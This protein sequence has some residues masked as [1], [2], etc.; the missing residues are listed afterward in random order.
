[1]SV[2]SRKIH[3]TIVDDIINKI[4]KGQLKSNQQLPTNKVLA[5]EYS[6]SEVTVRKSILELCNRGYLHSVERV[7]TF[8]KDRSNREERYSVTLSKEINF[9]EPIDSQTIESI[10][11]ALS[12][13]ENHQ[14]LQSVDTRK[15][16]Y[17]DSIPVCYEIDSLFFK[18]KYKEH[19]MLETVEKKQN[20]LH[21]LLDGFNVKK[22]CEITMKSP[23]EFIRKKL[24]LSEDT[25]TFCFSISYY[26]LKGHPIAKSVYY[27][28]GSNVKL[29]GYLVND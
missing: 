28:S 19:T 7:G 3:E 2:I 26:T 12:V 21:A 1:M 13:V 8:V 6:T 16:Q 4:A 15:V 24:L 9:T 5:K 18:G 23:E 17:S 27:V 11:L 14:Y 22:K 29:K 25:P 20:Y 10:H